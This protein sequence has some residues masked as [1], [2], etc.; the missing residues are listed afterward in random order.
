MSVGAIS[1][2]AE[3]L[4]LPLAIQGAFK[5]PTSISR[6]RYV[7]A[8]RSVRDGDRSTQT[9]SDARSRS[10]DTATGL[11]R[12]TTPRSRAIAAPA[13]DTTFQRNADGD[14]LTLSSRSGAG[15]GASAGGSS[16]PC[17]PIDT[18]P[19]ATPEQTIAKAER[20]LQT[21]MAPADGSS[22]DLAVAAKASSMESDARAELRKQDE[23]RSRGEGSSARGYASAAT[24]SARPGGLDV[25]A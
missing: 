10:A 20:I 5:S 3:G 23:A 1:S 7:D 21:A 13:R 2:L 22:P 6:T 8:V 19:G 16:T 9:T 15:A 14:T 12:L 18:T 11:D 25:V 17:T 4:T 24:A